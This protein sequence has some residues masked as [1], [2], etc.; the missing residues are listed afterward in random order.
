MKTQHS[1]TFALALATTALT[2]VPAANAESLDIQEAV[3]RAFGIMQEQKW[4][5]AQ[6]ILAKVIETYLDRKKNFGGKFGV[7]YYNKGICELKIAGKLKS[8]GGQENLDKAGTYYDMAIASFDECYEIPTDG[9]GANP[10]HKT[11]LLY[12]GQA[13]LG[14]ENYKDAI[15]AFQKFLTERDKTD[16]F[17]PATLYASLAICHYKLEKPDIQAG[18]KFFES[19]LQNKERWKTPDAAIVTTFQALTYAVITAK[20]EQALIDFLN[21]NRAAITLK[22]FQMVEYTPFFQKLAAEA[23]EADMLYATFNLFAL[24]PGTKVAINDISVLSEQLAA[25]KPAGIKDGN[26]LIY[27]DK[28]K[29]HLET[30]RASNLSGDPAEVLALRALAFTHL[31]NKNP[32]GA[33]GCY[34]QLELYFNKSKK[35]EENLFNLIH[36]SYMINEVFLTE[37]YGSIFLKDFPESKHTEAVRSLML[38]SLFSSGEYVK[39]I[40]VA[41]RL[42]DKLEKGTKQHDICIHV[43]GGSKFYLG[44]YVDAHPLLE[45]HVKE[46]PKSEFK[47]ASRYFEASNLSRLEMWQPAAKKLDAFLND[48]PSAKENNFLPFAL[49]DRANVHF[50]EG[51]NKQALTHLNR[52][53]KEFTGTNIEDSTY[54]LKGNI[55]QADGVLD[56]AKTYYVK[57]LEI[58]EHRDNAAVTAESLYYL[59]GLLGAEKVG[60][61]PNPNIK[62]A[63]PY[64]D[65]FWKEFQDSPYKAQ[66]AVAGIAALNAA[67]RGDEALTNL[68]STIAEM[69]KDPNPAGLDQAIGSY[70]KYYLLNLKAKNVSDADAADQLKDHYYK[71]PGIDSSDTRTLAMLRIAIIG[72]YEDALKKAQEDKDESRITT[73]QA[74]INTL[75]KELKN[76]FPI[77]KLSDFVLVRIG[78]HLR[79]KTAAPRQALPYYEE[80]LKRQAVAGRSRAQFGIADILGQSDSAADQDKAIA[81]LNEIIATNKDSKTIRGDANYR[82]CEVYAKRGDWDKAEAACT[83]QLKEYTQEKARVS[84][85]LALSFDKRN[86]YDKAIANYILCYGTYNSLPE[87]SIPSMN[88]ASELMWE[89]GQEKGSKSGKQLA[90]ETAANYIESSR[91]SFDKVKDEL[92]DEVREAWLSTEAR[93]KMMEGSGAIKTLK[94]IEEEEANR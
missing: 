21:Q 53:E 12:K 65:K 31:T 33:F 66:V 76:D 39:C 60:K 46:Y 73:N 80:R 57:A 29:K 42:K 4:E 10:F 17:D 92:S 90:Y 83:V 84:F 51:E 35:R 89:H 72:V 27:K 24:I 58:S 40:E 28:L 77:E 59:V 9:A 49:Y 82:L 2:A 75:F 91:A 68:Q 85:L 48:F 52:I 93:V 37:E 34:L 54:N 61:E 19:I 94:E 1:I 50:A 26:E 62:D 64:Y 11:S 22:P 25:Y 32:R 8:A 71:F 81:T 7:L 5:E 67:G 14:A 3:P 45:Q 38:T 15:T 74:R 69:G 41:E 63:I 13:L 88:R 47:I 30:L 20:K 18:N 23:L 6:G 43:L 16:K 86:Q 87:V 56:E 78:D 70:T 55:L 36:T 44:Q 79:T